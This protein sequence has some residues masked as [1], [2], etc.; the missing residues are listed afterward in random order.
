MRPLPPVNCIP[1]FPEERGALLALLESLTPFLWDADTVCAGWSVKDL[2]SHLV[3]DDLGRLSRGR[4]HHFGS[5]FVP[6]GTD[7]PRPGVVVASA[8]GRFEIELLDYINNQNETWVA[9]TRRLSARVLIDL[10][11]TSG[12]EMQAYWESL[13][14]SATGDPVSWAGP[15][16]APVW[17]DVAREYTERW[18]HQQQIRDAVAAPGLREGAAMKAVLDTFVRALPYSYRSL[19]AP[20]GTHLRLQFTPPESVTRDVRR[21]PGE[22]PVLAYSLYRYEGRWI[23]FTDVDDPPHAEVSMDTETA[24]RLFTRSL[25]KSEAV[26]RSTISGDR[27]LAGRVMDTLAIIA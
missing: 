17:L 25:P 3:A 4:D 24:W 5:L 13:D 12:E 22:A 8:P 19:H 7:D 14:L 2:V 9:A 1:L 21:D 23:L 18:H 20:D 10:L 15:D 11:R 6:H 27:A 26:T 16:P